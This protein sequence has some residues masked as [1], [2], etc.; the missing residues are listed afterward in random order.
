MTSRLIIL[1]LTHHQCVYTYYKYSIKGRETPPKID[2]FLYEQ[3]QRTRHALF[4]DPPGIIEDKTA[5]D[6]KR[7]QQ[8]RSTSGVLCCCILPWVEL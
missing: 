3:M 2:T 7:Q 4:I 8:Q 1:H 5:Q 6:R